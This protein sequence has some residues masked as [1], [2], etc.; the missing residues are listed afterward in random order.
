[1][2]FMNIRHA[3]KSI[4]MQFDTIHSERHHTTLNTLKWQGERMKAYI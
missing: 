2:N 4:S 3:F 1:M